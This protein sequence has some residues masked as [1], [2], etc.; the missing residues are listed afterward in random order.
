MFF[1]RQNGNNFLG[2]NKLNEKSNF[3]V[4]NYFH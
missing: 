2:Y 3:P 1:D 4:P